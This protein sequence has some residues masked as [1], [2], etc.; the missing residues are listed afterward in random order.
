MRFRRFVIYPGFGFTLAAVLFLSAC[1]APNSSP[2]AD[3]AATSAPS[4]PAETAELPDES[5]AEDLRA[6]PELLAQLEGAGIT[7]NERGEITALKLSN[8]TPELLQTAVA[9]PTL[10]KLSLYGQSIDDDS[11]AVIAQA[12][13]L[14]ELNFEKAAFTDEGLAQLKRLP[15][16]TSIDL[17]LTAFSDAGAAHLA[18]IPSLRYFKGVR[19]AITDQGLEILARNPNWMP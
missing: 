2:D 17:K 18:E 8:P 6:T 15:Q 3:T 5:A 10:V 9:I 12:A 13:G 11:L 14:K 1:S 16:L 19:T 4:S 7:Q